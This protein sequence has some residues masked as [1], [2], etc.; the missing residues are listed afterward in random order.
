MSQIKNGVFYIGSTSFFE[1]RKDPTRSPDGSQMVPMRSRKA[2]T[3][4]PDGSQ[5]AHMRPP[6]VPRSPPGD[7]REACVFVAPRGGL[8]EHVPNREL[9]VSFVFSQ[10]F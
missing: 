6:D 5:M 7:I 9:C 3:G 2:P 8:V 10:L 4:P 1:F